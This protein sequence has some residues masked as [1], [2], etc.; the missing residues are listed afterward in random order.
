MKLIQNGLTAATIT[1]SGQ[2]G[3][4]TV[5]ISITEGDGIAIEIY[6]N[7]FGICSVTEGQDG[8]I[9]PRWVYPQVGKEREPSTKAIPWKIALGVKQQAI[10]RLEQLLLMVEQS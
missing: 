8:N 10:Q 1:L 2:Q 9:Y 6:K 4:D 3:T 5:S 7:E